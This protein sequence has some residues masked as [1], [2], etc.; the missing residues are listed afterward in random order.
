MR[1]TRR[2]PQKRHQSKNVRTIPLHRKPEGNPAARRTE[3]RKRA[4]TQFFSKKGSWLRRNA[5]TIA[6]EVPT[7]G[8]TNLLWGRMHMRNQ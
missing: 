5:V 8:E 7:C 4:L 6:Q 1:R 3:K 2:F